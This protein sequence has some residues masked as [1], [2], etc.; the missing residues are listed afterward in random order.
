[1]RLICLTQ[2]SKLNFSFNLLPCKNCCFYFIEQQI[3]RWHHCEKNSSRRFAMFSNLFH[4]N[5]SNICSP[6][7][8]EI[9]RSVFY[10]FLND[11][12]LY[13][14]QAEK[15]ANAG[16]FK[17]ITMFS[18]FDEVNLGNL[19]PLFVLPL[20]LKSFLILFRSNDLLFSIL[21]FLTWFQFF[22]HFRFL[23]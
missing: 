6:I 10:Q 3:F 11:N 1:M 16:S 20:C 19:F 21:E 2:S 7:P 4:W 15:F 14:V 17:P 8:L 5:K 12:D 23:V 18:D 13:F 9:A 22:R